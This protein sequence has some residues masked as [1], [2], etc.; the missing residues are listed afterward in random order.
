MAEMTHPNKRRAERRLA[1]KA[2]ALLVDSDHKRIANTAFAV[3]LSQLGA[4]IRTP[5]RLEPGQRV[6]VIPR[7]GKAYAIPSRVIW[8]NASQSDSDSEAGLA[9]LEPQIP[10]SSLIAE[11][12]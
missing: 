6:T 1:S 7:E 8:V 3:D 2:I 11:M 12:L 4:R 5:I 9:F 10:S